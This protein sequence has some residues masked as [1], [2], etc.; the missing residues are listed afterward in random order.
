METQALSGKFEAATKLSDYFGVDLQDTANQKFWNCICFENN[1]IKGSWNFVN[2]NFIEDGKSKRYQYLIFLCEQYIKDLESDSFIIKEYE[3][4][5][6][7]FSNFEFFSDDISTT[8]NI[9]DENYQYL[10]DLAFSGSG[11]AAL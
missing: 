10:H 6:R 9:T 3:E 1:P 8:D 2:I 7:K 11:S 5:H 4:L